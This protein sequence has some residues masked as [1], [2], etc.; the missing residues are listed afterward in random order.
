MDQPDD[1][2]TRVAM[3]A[4]VTFDLKDLQASFLEHLAGSGHPKY[5]SA[6]T[7]LTDY[8]RG[9]WLSEQLARLTYKPGVTMEIVPSH[10][11]G[12]G[13]EWSVKVTME[14]EDTYKPG[15]TT[16]VS[17]QYPVWHSEAIDENTFVRQVARVLQDLEIHESREWLKRDGAIW[18]NPH[19]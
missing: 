16:K 4:K 6:E 15:E 14:V 17:G 11:G 3:S 8:S 9:R 1:V 5:P 2:Y 7:P 18:D 19:K 10:L 13:A 12:F